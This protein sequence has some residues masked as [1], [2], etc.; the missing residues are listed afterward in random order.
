ML[1]FSSSEMRWMQRIQEGAMQDTCI[2][3]DYSQGDLDDYGNVSNP[4]YTDSE[5]TRCGLDPQS[6]TEVMDGTQ[7]IVSDAA[8]RLPLNT[9]IDNL[10]RVRITHRFG[11]A[12]A[13]PIIYEV[14]GQPAQGPS[15]IVVQL[16]SVTRPD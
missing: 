2:V 15:G 5:P 6:Q 3:M 1:P 12:L 16:R 9:A 10:D 8:L 4:E 13:T 11:S 14:I 7:V